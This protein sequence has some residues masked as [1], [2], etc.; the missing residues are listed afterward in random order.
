[1]RIADRLERLRDLVER[2]HGGCEDTT[3][4]MATAMRHGHWLVAIETWASSGASDAEFDRLYAVL[5]ATY[6]FFGRAYKAE[7]AEFCKIPSAECSCGAYV[8]EPEDVDYHCS[9]CGK[10]VPR[11]AEVAS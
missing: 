11:P 10:Q 4:T 9:N 8:Y 3:C 7:S 5:P 1:M 2:D 6:R